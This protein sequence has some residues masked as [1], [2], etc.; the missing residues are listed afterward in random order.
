MTCFAV[1]TA[2]LVLC[3]NADHLKSALMWILWSFYLIRGT[4][5]SLSVRLYDF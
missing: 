4:S 2:E 3:T 1:D 5:G